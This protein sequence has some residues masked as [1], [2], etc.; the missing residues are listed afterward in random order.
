MNPGEGRSSR[1]AC[2]W[3]LLLLACALP[4]G[5][6][7][8]RARVEQNLMALRD[9]PQRIGGALEQY[10]VGCSD[11]LEV[12]SRGRPEPAGKYMV[13]PTGR[14]DLGSLGAVRVEGRT[15]RE[16]AEIIA[17]KSGQSVSNVAVR[18]AAFR[19]QYLLLTGQVSGW[20]RTVPYQGQE[21]LLDLLQRVG[22]IASGAELT[23]VYVVRTHLEESKRPEVFH[24]DL[25]AIVMRH[26]DRTNLRLMP[27]DQ[28]YIGE[29]TQAQFEKAF[30]PWLRPIYQVFWN[31]RPDS[32]PAPPPAPPSTSSR[33][34]V[35]A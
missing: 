33:W 12:R 5:C 29:S 2:R 32:G 9:D 11:V 20:Q 30:P 3:A 7:S 1:L 21:T 27:F 25:K 8:D 31:M 26:D 16:T 10:R 13:A 19:S 35:G 28:I 23:D 18:I 14:I 34:V 17:A 24:V 4:A 15:L 22:G 6:A